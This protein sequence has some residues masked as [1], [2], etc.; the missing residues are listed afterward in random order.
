MK[1]ITDEEIFKIARPIWKNMNASSNQIDYEGFSR[2]F[3]NELKKIITKGRFEAQCKKHKILTSLIADAEPI[4]CIRR[5]EGIGVIFRQLSSSQE[6]E[7][8]GNLI[9]SLENGKA[10]VLDATIY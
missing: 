7:F 10:E 4:A 1:Y 8:M 6:G 2:D 3:S 5:K 9:I